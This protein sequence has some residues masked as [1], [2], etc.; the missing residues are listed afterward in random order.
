VY[1]KV[2]IQLRIA[3]LVFRSGLPN[4]RTNCN[5]ISE[6]LLYLHTNITCTRASV[7]ITTATSTT[8]TSITMTTITCTRS[9]NTSRAAAA[10]ATTTTTTTTTTTSSGSYPS[11]LLRHRSSS[12]HVGFMADNVP[13]RRVFSRYFHFPFQFSFHQLLCIHQSSYQTTPH[14][15]LSFFG[16]EGLVK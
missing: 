8:T 4:I 6:G 16:T 9:T 3:F 2:C 11:A 7:I 10:A 5:R 13:S 12:S 15:C 14:F 1:F